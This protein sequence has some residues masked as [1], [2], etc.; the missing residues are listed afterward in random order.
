[1]CT[2]SFLSV[3]LFVALDPANPMFYPF[4]C[5]LTK[6]DAFW[7]DVIHTDRGIYGTLTYMGT[8]EFYAN[9]G[10]RPQPGCPLIGTPLSNSGNFLN[11]MII[12]ITIY[13]YRIV[14]SY[15]YSIN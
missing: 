12:I 11:A 3:K 9:H 15:R 13:E 6:D 1:V 4:G 14:D 5:Y 8:A 7:I 2:Y 10:T